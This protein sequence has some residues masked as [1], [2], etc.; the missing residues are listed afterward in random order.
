MS[1]NEQQVEQEVETEPVQEADA[2]ADSPEAAP[3]AD[4]SRP[5]ADEPGA[6]DPAPQSV[7]PPEDSADEQEMTPEDFEKAATQS[8]A[9][10]KRFRGR[11]IDRFGSEGEN[12]IDC[13]LCLDQHKGL[14]DRRHAGQ[15]PREIVNAIMAYLGLQ[16]EQ[17]Y[18]QSGKHQPCS[19]C[20]GKGKVKTG[21]TVAEHVNVVCPECKGFG[22]TPPPG[23]AQTEPGNG[24]LEPAHVP[25]PTD[26]IEQGDFDN[27]GEPRML[28]DGR[29]N[30][31][32]GKQPA[33]KT[34]V[35][36]WGITANLGRV[37]T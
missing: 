28:P 34:P 18:K 24:T 25:P 26:D 35:E 3:T 14:V 30:P 17:E 27:W 4:P 37:A 33:F 12:L 29:P 32:Y 2:P 23:T 6:D 16:V 36:P 13:P 9:D 7:T 19:F 31:N 5:G 22:Y 15:Y 20:D 1:E 10:W 11:T 8:G 21:S